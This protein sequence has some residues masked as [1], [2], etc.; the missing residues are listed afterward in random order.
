MKRK[1]WKPIFVLF[2]IGNL[3]TCIEPYTPNLG[4]FESLLVVDAL[5]TDEN[6][7]NYVKISRTVATAGQD[8][9]TVKG[10]Q[11]TVTDD[12]GEIACFTEKGDGVYKSDSTVFRGETGRTYTLHIK[13]SDGNEYKSDPCMLSPVQDIDTIYYKLDEEIIDNDIKS[14][15]RLYVKSKSTTGCGYNRWTYHE[16]WKIEA[17][18]AQ[19]SVYVDS[20]T[21]LPYK[22][23]KRFCYANKKSGDIIIKPAQENIDQPLF[24]IASQL[25]PRLLIEYCLE[26]KQLS[27]S[28]E[29]YEFWNCMKQIGESGSSIFDK[30]PFQ[31]SGNVHNVNA[32][33]QKVLGYFQVSGVKMMRRYITYKQAKEAGVIRYI[34]PCTAILAERTRD[35]STWDKVYKS[36]ISGGLIFVRPVFDPGGLAKMMFVTPLCGDCT[37]SGN[38][39]KPDFWKDL[40]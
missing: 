38:L 37:L 23:Y 27:I 22:P 12:S 17:Y 2:I 9:E 16:W 18:Y 13:T 29:E 40:Q 34:Y 31:I 20:A 3:F 35:L 21:F 33:D 19:E 24:F 36:Y 28:K 14:G 4:R 7:S 5:L 32:P 15:L 6:A 26:L 39:A 30:Q 10:A 1:L 25:S 11:V 8:P